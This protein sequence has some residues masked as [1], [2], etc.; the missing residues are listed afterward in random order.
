M[1]PALPGRLLR[2]VVGPCE[3]MVPRIE[4]LSERYAGRVKFC[5]ADSDANRKLRIKFLVAALP[6]LVLVH[7]G[8]KT[9]LF[10]EAVTSEALARRIDAVLEA[11]SAPTTSPL[12]W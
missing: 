5:R 10:D 2:A 11:G 3:N 7:D 8:N 4:E 9:P 6:Y 1:R 12:S